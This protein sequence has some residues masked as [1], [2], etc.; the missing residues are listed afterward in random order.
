MSL[1]PAKELD[2][3]LLV[4][5]PRDFTSH[6][7]VARLRRKLHMKRIGHAGTLD[8][9]A[10]G[11]LVMLIGKSTRISQYLISQDKVYEGE[12]TL[13]V[14]TNSQDADGE[15]VSTQ[16]VPPLTEAQVRAALAG[17]LGDQYQTPPMFSAIKK[18]GVPLY[19][20]ARQGEEIE[21]EPR[22]IRVMAFELLGFASPKITFRLA[23]TKGTYVRSIAHDLGQKLGCGAHLSALRRTKSGTMDISQAMTLEG[24]EALSHADIGKRLLPAHAVAPSHAL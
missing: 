12:I 24:I 10:T 4:D 5:K 13:G 18:D 7:V 14:T 20:L 23:C 2:G 1:Q 15:V 22:F 16:E 3:V 19:K 17:F 8:P 21:R 9:L 11:L 6:D